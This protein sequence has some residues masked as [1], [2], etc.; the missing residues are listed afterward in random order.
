M[1]RFARLVLPGWVHHVTQRGNNRQI[2]FISDVSRLL[3][4]RLLAQYF[5]MHGLA[6]IGY[7][8]MGNHVHL[9]VI[10]G[11]K[12]SLAQGIGRLHHDFAC[13][14]NVQFGKNGHLWQNRFFSCPVEKDRVWGMLSYIELNPLRAG[15]VEYAWDW[16][17][18]SARAHV[19]GVDPSG[20][21]DMELWRNHFDAARW[22]A[23]LEQM[24]AERTLAARLRKATTAGR[25]FGSEATARQL[26]QE[27]GYAL[28]PRRRGRKPKD[29][30]RMTE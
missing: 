7:C 18:S 16:E 12:D 8:L 30:S 5:P 27:L 23:Y 11:S 9:A 2:I 13:W 15:L 29:S 19:A 10:P 17:W 3:Y 14:H 1:T 28:L 4:L 25:F 26:E 21:L 6:L 24:A 20:L 22:K